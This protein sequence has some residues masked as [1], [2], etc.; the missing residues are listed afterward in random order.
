MATR[1]KVEPE[2][3]AE[4]FQ[5]PEDAQPGNLPDEKDEIIKSLRAQI[6]SMEKDGK[7]L[8]PAEIKPVPAD[9]PLGDIWEEYIDV[10]VPR[11]GRGQEK[12]FYVSVNGRNAQ[13][14]A[15]GKMHH[16][17]KPLA[18]ALLASLE[19][20]ARAEQFAEDLPH[21]AAPASFAELMTVIN[22]L[23]N[24]LRSSGITV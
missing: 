18:L 10:V 7:H 5:M 22:D 1:N 15:D 19:A 23:K 3:V 4:E 14:P 2:T 11:H 12:C 13:I 16:I 8:V 6:A 24:K 17:R 21:D 9:N 20:E